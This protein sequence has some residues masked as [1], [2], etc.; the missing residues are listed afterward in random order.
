MRGAS[1]PP[2]PP[3]PTTKRFWTKKVNPTNY[4]SLSRNFIGEPEFVLEKMFISRFIP[5]DFREMVNL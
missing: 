3:P 4:V 2:P 1:F 5:F